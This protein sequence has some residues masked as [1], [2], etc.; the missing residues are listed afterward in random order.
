MIKGFFFGISISAIGSKVFVKDFNH[1]LQVVDTS[2]GK[3][4]E[5]ASRYSLNT[6]IEMML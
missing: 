5:L 1:V 2:S 4:L 6:Y 3:A